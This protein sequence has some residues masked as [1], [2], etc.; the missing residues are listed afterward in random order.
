ME[1]VHSDIDEVILN[2]YIVVYH[3]QCDV[4]SSQQNECCD[5]RA[6][7]TLN[8]KITYCYSLVIFYYDSLTD[9]NSIKRTEFE[10]FQNNH[11]LQVIADARK[12]YDLKFEACFAGFHERH[13]HPLILNFVKNTHYNIFC[14]G[15]YQSFPPPLNGYKYSVSCDEDKQKTL[16]VLEVIGTELSNIKS[17]TNKDRKT[18]KEKAKINM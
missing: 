5:T 2:G 3:F 1:F 17:A 18:E 7:W 9:I 11:Y 4:V 10:Y 16:D 6:S 12:F 13:Q 8:S 15:R 14:V